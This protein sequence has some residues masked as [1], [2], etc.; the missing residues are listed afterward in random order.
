MKEWTLQEL[1]AAIYAL[2]AER[3]RLRQQQRHLQSLRA[4]VAARGEVSARL[5]KWTEDEIDALYRL[6]SDGSLAPSTD[7]PL[8]DWIRRTFKRTEV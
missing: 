4:Q 8:R 2:T 6:V 3:A 7:T 1:D 5:E